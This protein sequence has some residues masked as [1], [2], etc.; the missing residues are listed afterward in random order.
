MLPGQTYSI[1]EI[2][3]LH[4]LQAA[5]LKDQQLH[6]LLGSEVVDPFF[7]ADLDLALDLHRVAD[8]ARPLAWSSLAG[9]RAPG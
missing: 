2:K 5:V 8:R 6:E 1:A 4:G 7:D 3:I 9:I